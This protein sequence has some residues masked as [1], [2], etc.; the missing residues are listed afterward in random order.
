MPDVALARPGPATFCR[1][2][3]LSLVLRSR[4]SGSNP[5]AQCWFAV[6][7]VPT[8][9]VTGAAVRA[10]SV[11]GAIQR[12]AHEAFKRAAEETAG[13]STMGGKG[14]MRADRGA[15]R[16][17]ARLSHAGGGPSTKGST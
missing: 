11:T 3:V 2:D 13:R 15:D 9:G 16:I 1:L 8:S 4:G 14:F 10:R 5:T 17:P 6:L 12:L 7:L